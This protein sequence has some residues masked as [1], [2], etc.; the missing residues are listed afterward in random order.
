MFAGSYNAKL[1]AFFHTRF[2]TG[3]TFIIMFKYTSFYSIPDIITEYS[4]TV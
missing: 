3:K 4:N 1:Y 2:A